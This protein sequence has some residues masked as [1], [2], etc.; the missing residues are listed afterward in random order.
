MAKIW[1]NSIISWS[2]CNYI[3]FLSLYCFT[4]SR[5]ENFSVASSEFLPCVF[6]E[7]RDINRLLGSYIGLGVVMSWTWIPIFNY[8]ILY[9]NIFFTFLFRGIER[10]FYF[11]TTFGL[12][13]WVEINSVF[14]HLVF[15]I[16]S[17]TWSINYFKYYKFK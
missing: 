1:R 3:F 5:F 6:N 2:R 15:V 17:W 16:G 12:V 10:L 13:F 7:F 4:A 8:S 14:C 9:L 11:W